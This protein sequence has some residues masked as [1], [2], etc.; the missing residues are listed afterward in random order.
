MYNF[1]SFLRVVIEPLIYSSSIFFLFFLLGIFLMYI[2]N[3]SEER[4]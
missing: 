4:L 2:S 3:R 1:K